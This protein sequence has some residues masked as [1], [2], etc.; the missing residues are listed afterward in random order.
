[1]IAGQIMLIIFGASLV[2]N[3]FLF[4]VVM[5]QKMVIKTLQEINE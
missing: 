2:L 5:L 1:M 4:A 3:G